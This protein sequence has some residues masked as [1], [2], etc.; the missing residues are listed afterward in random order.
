MLLQAN[1]AE[2]PTVVE[3]IRETHDKAP[4]STSDERSRRCAVV[5]KLDKIKERTKK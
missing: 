2:T 5:S 4:S 3:R 1:R